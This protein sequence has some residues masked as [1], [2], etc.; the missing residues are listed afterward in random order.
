MMADTVSQNVG[1][2][3]KPKGLSG[4][5]FPDVGVVAFVPE[6]WG[7]LWM[8]GTVLPGSQYFHVVWADLRGMGET[9]W[10]WKARLHRPSCFLRVYSV[11]AG[12]GFHSFRPAWLSSWMRRKGCER[13]IASSAGVNMS[14]TLAS[15]FRY[16]LDAP[17]TVVILSLMS[18]LFL[19]RAAAG[20]GEVQLLKR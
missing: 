18:I 14:F 4:P 5:L 19:H 3:I 6:E 2:G 9:G 13:N 12:R 20:Q 8:S 16:V 17:L 15:I 1:Q 10:W 7:G 11:S